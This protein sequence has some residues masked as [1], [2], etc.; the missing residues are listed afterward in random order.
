MSAHTQRHPLY[1]AAIDADDAYSA[2]ITATY[3]KKHDRWDL[4]YPL[5]P[6]IAAAYEAKKYA[7]LDWLEHM[8]EQRR[9]ARGQ[10]D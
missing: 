5:H 10:H 9:A 7:D 2:V 8:Q 6:A 3:G 4:P 1:Q